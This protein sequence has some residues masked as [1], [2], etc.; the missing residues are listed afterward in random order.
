[1]PKLKRK[2]A[3][4]ITDIKSQMDEHQG[5]VIKDNNYITG[6]MR[7]LRRSLRDIKDHHIED[8]T[9]LK[10]LSDFSF[11]DLRPCRYEGWAENRSYQPNHP[12]YDPQNPDKKK[13][14]EAICFLY[15]SI[16]IDKKKYWV[17]VKLH[18]YFKGEVLYTMESK[19]PDDMILGLPKYLEN[20]G[21]R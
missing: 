14:E 4:H 21:M 5:V 3:L 15:Y 20:V 7:V 18:K 11:D 9:L 16:I 2:A 19:K 12:K 1:M 8:V 6:E 17:N 13:H 10:W